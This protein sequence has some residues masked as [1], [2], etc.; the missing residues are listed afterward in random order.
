M[1]TPLRKSIGP[2]GE[3][4][5]AVRASDREKDT[6]VIFTSD[7]GP[8]INLPERMLLGGNRPWHVGS[9]GALR[10]AKESTYEGGVRV[11]LIVHWPGRFAGGS[12]RAEM[13][14]TMDLYATLVRLGTGATSPHPIDGYD[15]TAWLE[16]TAAESP[17]QEFFYFDAD[18]LDGIRA[19]SWKL[20]LRDGVELFQLDLDP[21]ERHNRE[22]EHPEIVAALKKRLLDMAGET[23]ARRTW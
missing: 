9:A 21:A 11:P 1:A 2:V 6:I 7:N 18:R 13:A 3:V 4:L 5:E 17:R 16:G 20:R 10:M 15:L 12:E 23:G 8:W 14:A 22:K 19:G